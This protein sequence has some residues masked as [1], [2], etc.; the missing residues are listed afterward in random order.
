MTVPLKP[1]KPHKGVGRPKN[2][3]QRD[4]HIEMMRPALAKR[5]QDLGLEANEA[6]LRTVRQELLGTNYGKMIW[7]ASRDDEI[8]KDRI[9][10]CNA[11]ARMVIAGWNAIG[12][13]PFPQNAS[14]TV[15]N[16][17]TFTDPDQRPR[18]NLS[19]EEYAAKQKAA[20]DMS[21]R[22]KR[23]VVDALGVR[24]QEFLDVLT[25]DAKPKRDFL[26]LVDSVSNYHNMFDKRN[27]LW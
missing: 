24:T 21:K 8:A 26:H 6:N 27:R 17:E 18:E 14:I 7:A 3:K 22:C 23:L 2:V 5:C 20:V 13:R 19:D 25:Y 16:E 12:A 10:C 15:L 11:I 1:I 4:E 9:A